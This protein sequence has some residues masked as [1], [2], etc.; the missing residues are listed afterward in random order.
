MT[1]S[2]KDMVFFVLLITAAAAFIVKLDDMI[3]FAARLMGLLLPLTAGAVIA[4]VLDAPE[5]AAEEL[6]GNI[7]CSMSQRKKRIAA[8]LLIY[9]SIAAL[10]AAVMAFVLPQLTESIRLFANSFDGY[11]SNFI[12][13]AESMKKRDVLTELL[14]EMIS[15]LVGAAG[16]IIPHIAEKAY[17]FTS[18]MLTAVADTLIAAVVSVYLLID[19]ERFVSIAG[20]VLGAYLPEERFCPYVRTVGLVTGCFSRFICGQITE[21]AVL[22]GLCFAGMLVFGFDYPL[23]IS[24]IIGVTALIPV[25]GAFIG[26]VPSALMLMLIR[27]SQALWFVVFI[28]V[29]QQLENNFIYPR[30]VGRSVGLPP[31]V[32]LTAMLAGAGIA[33]TAGLMIGIPAASAV[34]LLVRDD[35]NRRLAAKGAAHKA[36]DGS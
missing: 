4:A 10:I 15:E 24:V 27:P 16:D 31:L 26:T 2:R 8:V 12:R 29:L 3:H 18:G 20:R 14:G 22:G 21:A 19:K 32:I 1:Q 34:Y 25:I 13:Y 23:L 36:P 5:K 11:Y 6:I 7:F 28:T 33:G 30:I 35:V 9:V 17:S